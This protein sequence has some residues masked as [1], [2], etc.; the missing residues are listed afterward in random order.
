MIFVGGPLHGQN[1]HVEETTPIDGPPV[2]P[3]AFVDLATGEMWQLKPV[4]F[5]LQ[6]A[7]PSPTGPV[8][9][10][11]VKTWTHQVYV[12]PS[13]GGQSPEQ[14]KG[15]LTDA[16]MLWWFTTGT[17]GA[18]NTT[19]PPALAAQNG[20]HTTYLATCQG[21]PHP[22]E[23]MAFDTLADR[24][25]WAT[26]HIDTTGHKVTFDQHTTEETPHAS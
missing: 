3:P 2:L 6:A 24:A 18:P 13:L 22:P 16:V 17:Q 4:S 8:P 14:M 25:L 5:R 20:Y 23:P 26:A 7:V 11:P 12:H 15:N 21:C 9:V 19:P 1:I 10:G